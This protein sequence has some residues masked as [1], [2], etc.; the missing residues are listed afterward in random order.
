MKVRLFGIFISLI[1]M[2]NAGAVSDQDLPL[3][4]QDPAVKRSI[5]PNGLSCYAA[6]NKT[7]K[8]AADFTLVRRDYEGKEELFSQKNVV[9]SSEQVVDSMLLSLMRRVEK[10]AAPADCAVIVCG[11]IDA[12]SV[13]T[14]HACNFFPQ[15]EHH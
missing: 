5:F 12:G 1:G 8:G 15:E 13:M 6:E 14:K 9:L 2:L 11:D 4:P 10:D 3:L 7:C